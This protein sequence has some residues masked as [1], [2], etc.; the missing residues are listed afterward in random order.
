M[1]K[2]YLTDYVGVDMIG[3][4]KYV[5]LNV[6]M[7][8]RKCIYTM[9]IYISIFVFMLLPCFDLMFVGNENSAF[10][11][12]KLRNWHLMIFL[13]KNEAFR[14]LNLIFFIAKKLCL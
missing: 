1:A 13:I 7:V 4:K 5:M 12:L 8:T 10:N 11:Q 9:Y 3:L 14:Y 6:Q 2:H